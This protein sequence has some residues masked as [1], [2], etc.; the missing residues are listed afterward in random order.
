MSEQTRNAAAPD[1]A[2][3][4]VAVRIVNGVARLHPALAA[5]RFW[6][7]LRRTTPRLLREHDVPGLQCSFA[8]S[9]RRV[10]TYC[11]GIA[12]T[13]RRDDVRSATRFRLGSIAK[14][15]TAIAALTL[16]RDGLLDLDAPAWRDIERCFRGASPDVQTLAQRITLRQLL[17]HAS[18]L[19]TVHPPRLAPAPPR[20]AWLQ[21]DALRFEREPGAMTEYTGVG[22]ALAEAIIECANGRLFVETMRDRVFGPLRL[23]RCA[24]E[25]DVAEDARDVASD[26]D[27]DNKPMRMPPSVCPASSGMVAT[28]EDMCRVMLACLEP[29]RVLPANLASLL[30]TP[31]PASVPHPTF[32]LG[33]HLYHGVDDRSLSHG[34]H[35]PGHRSL[36]VVIPRAK[37]VFC[38]ATNSERGADVLKPLTGLFRS[39]TIGA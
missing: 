32:T 22:Y 15:M 1:A 28:T 17:S 2:R 16:V 9:D 26:H 20:T 24:Y 21:P 18:G 14:P 29:G 12:D 10:H 30:W 25:C 5:A 7:A 34:G 8:M 13:L 38:A 11:H 3:A 19:A 35:R 33:L 27:A 36:L 37:A 31:Q 4:G 6:E 39:I 23:D